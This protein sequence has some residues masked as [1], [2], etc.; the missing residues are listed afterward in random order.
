[1][2]LKKYILQVLVLHILLLRVRGNIPKARRAI[3]PG[4]NKHPTI[5]EHDLR[6]RAVIT[7]QHLQAITCRNIPDLDGYISKT[8]SNEVWVRWRKRDAQHTVIMMSQDTVQEEG[9]RQFQRVLPF[10]VAGQGRK[11]FAI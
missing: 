5:A 2:S 9:A 1:L 6:N 3:L 11:A 4:K 7:G 8:A 10:Q